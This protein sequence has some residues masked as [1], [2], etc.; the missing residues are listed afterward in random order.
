MI[1]PSGNAGPGVQY[2]VSTP[3]TGDQ[4][5]STYIERFDSI[6]KPLRK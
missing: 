4:M 3:A 2:H 1:T 6:S 5:S